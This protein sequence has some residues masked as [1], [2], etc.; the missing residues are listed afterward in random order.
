MGNVLRQNDD[1]SW[2]EATPLPPQGAVAKVEFWLRSKGFKIIPNLFAKW[3]E[4][5]LG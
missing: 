2:S 4:R 5:G 1:G 3:D